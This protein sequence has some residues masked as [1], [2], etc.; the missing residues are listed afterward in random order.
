[1]FVCDRRDMSDSA[2]KK[3]GAEAPLPRGGA[4]LSDRRSEPE[5]SR[6]SAPL[7]GQNKEKD[8]KKH[9]QMKN[10]DKK[11]KKKKKEEENRE[12]EQQESKKKKSKKEK[13]SRDHH[14]DHHHDDDDDDGLA[15]DVTAPVVK[16]GRSAKTVSAR[17]LERGALLLGLVAE[18]SSHALFVDLPHGLRARVDMRESQEQEDQRNHD[19]DDD[20]DDDRAA[21]DEMYAPGDV[22]VVAVVTAKPLV[23]SLDPALVC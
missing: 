14:H 16:H 18:A 9:K 15:E 6:E 8:T 12:E 23:V 1:M 17:T 3:R 22:L 13:K 11:K 7:F 5:R 19:D 4:R 21:A 10:T 20:D 2:S